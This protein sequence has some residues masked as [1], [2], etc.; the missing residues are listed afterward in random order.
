MKVTEGNVNN[1]NDKDILIVAGLELVGDS[2]INLEEASPVTEPLQPAKTP[3]A[4]FKTLPNS[5]ATSPA[6]G[7]TPPSAGGWSKGS[8]RPIQPI[9]TLNPYNPSW[10]IRAKVVSRGPKRA[11]NNPR[12]GGSSSVFSAEVMDEQ[13]TAI[14]ATFW[15]EAA[16]RFYDLLAEGVVAVFARGSVK[17]ANKKYSNVRN[18]Y[19]LSFDNSAE[20]SPC[21]DAEI[22]VSKIAVKLN[23]VAISH[24]AAY[25]DKR[26]PVDVVA[27]AT[28]VGTLSAIKRKSD[29]TEVTRRDVTL[30]DQGLKT[31]TLTLWDKNAEAIGDQLEAAIAGSGGAVIVA[32]SSCRVSS[33]NGVSLSTLGR[34]SVRIHPITD[35]EAPGTTALAA[36]WKEDGCTAETVHIGEGLSS[37]LKPGTG[38]SGGGGG[39]G[40][41]ELANLQ[42]VRN[43]CPAVVGEKP[44]YSTV[45]ASFALI[46][47]EQNLYYNAAPGNNRKVIEQ[48]G[49][50][51][52][53]Y[54][55][56]RYNSMTRR[57]IFSARLM[58]STGELPIQIFND[59]AETLLGVN[60][61]DLAAMRESEESQFRQVINQAVWSHWTV[62]VKAFSQEYQNEARS[63]Y[64]IMELK[65]INYV[66]ECKR[67]LDLLTTSAA[68]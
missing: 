17:P 57:Y 53:E 45:L 8:G 39:G 11:F 38:G 37:A 68:Q 22:D 29:N 26:M 49:E 7:P 1:V 61:D 33:Y 2:I 59:Q 18:D 54:D 35:D 21:S 31:V 47:P 25:V 51:Y 13:G 19:C 20:I 41:R 62:R 24:L 66:S 50:W 32:V 58:D 5:D 52:C 34:S 56:Q 10:A 67:L 43:G 12:P 48:D 28:S 44:V 46:D 60:A 42:T 6:A 9:A 55:G 63:R 23:P 64:A 16:D 15:R 65:P 27:M 40:S 3:A 36:W 30:V 4:A 14:E